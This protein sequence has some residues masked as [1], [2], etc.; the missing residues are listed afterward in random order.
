M[1]I[2]Q[3]QKDGWDVFPVGLGL[4]ADQEYMTRLTSAAQTREPGANFSTSGDP[5]KY[6]QELREIF[7]DIVLTPNVQLVD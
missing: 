6:E 1:Q 4:G 2:L 7:L 3:M 5:D